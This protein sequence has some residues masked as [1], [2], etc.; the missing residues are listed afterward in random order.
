K[1][2]DSWH[3]NHMEDPTSMS[4]GSIMPRYPWLLDDDLDTSNTRA[5]INAMRI[6]GVPYEKG[7]ENEANEHLMAQ[8]A[9]IVESLDG[10]GIKTRPDKEIVALI[11]YLQ[12][13][14]T[15]I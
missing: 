14:G 6:L 8:A 15:D 9:T 2:P 5:K 12:R 3:Y 11:A 4:P 13:L 1:Y 10:A 7:F